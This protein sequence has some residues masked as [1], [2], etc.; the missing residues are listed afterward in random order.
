MSRKEPAAGTEFPSGGDVSGSRARPSGIA[1]TNI[2]PAASTRRRRDTPTAVERRVIELHQAA[3]IRVER[4]ADTV[5]DIYRQGDEAPI[6]AR[7]VADRTTFER[8]E[9]VLA[10]DFDAGI[11]RR[12]STKAA[13]PPMIVMSWETWLRLLRRR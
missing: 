9:G 2:S 7:V 11:V 4:F 12:S 6:I 3:D 1:T 10:D 13:P 5:I 8:V